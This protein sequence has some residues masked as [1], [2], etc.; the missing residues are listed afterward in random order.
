MN[1]SATEVNLL[2][3]TKCTLEIKTT[4]GRASSSEWTFI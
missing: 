3:S 2:T 4:A 1:Y